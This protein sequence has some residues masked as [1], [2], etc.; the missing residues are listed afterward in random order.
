M[1]ITDTIEGIIEQTCWF[2]YDRTNDVLYLRLAEHREAPMFSEEVPEG[3]LLLRHAESDEPVGLT[4]VNWWKRFGQ[5]PFPDSLKELER[6]IEPWSQ[7][8]VA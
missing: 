6:R 8:L 2:H 4:I 1:V 5:G 7:R 3:S